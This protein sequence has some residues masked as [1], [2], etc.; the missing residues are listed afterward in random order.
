MYQAACGKEDCI[1]FFEERILET[2]Y[3]GLRV[4]FTYF[5]LLNQQRY[6][7]ISWV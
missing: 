6:Q 2:W 5:D 7:Y 3:V 4:V 1:I